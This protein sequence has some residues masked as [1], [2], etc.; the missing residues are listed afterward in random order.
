MRF[1][2]FV[3][4]LMIALDASADELPLPIADLQRT[5]PVDFAS[6]IA[7]ILKQ[8]CLACH[9]EKEAEGGLVLETIVSIR[10]GGDSGEGVV[11]RDVDSSLLMSRATGA[12]EPLM[13][14]EDNSVGARPLTPDE[15]G[16]LKLWIEQ[17]AVGTDGT[18]SPAIQWQPIPDS[19][20]SAYAMDVSPDGQLAAIGRANR[21]ALVD[22]ATQTELAFLED[23]SLEQPG[24]VDVDL[25]QSIRFSPDANRIAT[26][27]FRTVKIWKRTPLPIDAT[28]AP[29]QAASTWVA[30]AP[31]S[32]RYAWVNAI[33][34]IE[35][36][37]ASGEQRLHTLRGHLDRVSG[38][39][40]DRE[41]R[42]FSIDTSGHLIVWNASS[43]ERIA[44]HQLDASPVHLKVSP[45]SGNVATVDAQGRVHVMVLKDGS[46]QQRP[47]ESLAD[48]NDVTAVAI[49]D[50]P[51]PVLAIARTSHAVTLYS[52]GDAASQQTFEHGDT[53][54]AL[55]FTDDGQRLV[56]GGRNGES[57]VWNLAD[58]KLMATLQGERQTDLRVAQARRDA[59][60]QQASVERLGK[61][62][63]ELAKR[64]AAENEVLKKARE[65]HQKATDSLGEEQ[66]KRE[67]AL[68]AVSNS[69]AKITQST[70]T[71]SK[72]EATI[73][74]ATE[75]LAKAQTTTADASREL[76]KQQS[77]L[78]AAEEADHELALK[79]AALQKA[80]ADAEQRVVE[81]RQQIEERR[82]TVSAAKEDAS[83]S[84]AKIDAARQLSKQS[85]AAAE[86]AKKE[87]ETN[88]KKVS[89]LD[90]SVENQAS[91]V[92]KRLQALETAADAQARA[93]AEIP[94]HQQRIAAEKRRQVLLQHLAEQALASAD[95]AGNPV[96]ALAVDQDD[97][98]IA[99]AQADG[100]VRLFRSIDGQPLATFEMDERPAGISFVGQTLCGLRRQSPPLLW[101][102]RFQYRLERTIGSMNDPDVISDR[103]TAL[104]FRPDGLSIAIGSGAPSRSGEIKIV[105]VES[106]QV[107]RD[108]GEVHSDSVLGLAF[109]PDGRIL[110][111]SA[112]DK[113][114]RLLDVASGKTIRSLE[115]HTHH[116]LGIAWQDDGQTIA[117]AGADRE[118][119]IWDA[120]TG[121]QRRTISGF[122][123]EATAIAFVPG[124]Q[125]IVTTGADG[126]IR[127]S[128]V[129][130]GKTVR[131]FQ[132]DGDF[133]FTVSVTPD[134]KNLLAGGESGVV[135]AWSL[136]DG[137][138]QF[139]LDGE[140]SAD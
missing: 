123:K 85:M 121:Q 129:G 81:V 40:W 18:T 71:H 35:V 68:A 97:S 100:S 126:Q 108:F 4:S 39:G 29:L 58:G 83:E 23:T 130:S 132:A 62:S 63:E 6:E 11:P 112:A 12:E 1:P 67:E 2:L 48:E 38:L 75:L 74:A 14:P 96:V 102:S 64:L 84:Q 51:Q 22:L 116:V 44:E 127:L 9:H 15:L 128:D 21:V 94:S 53:V 65:E 110:A 36:W 70:E 135:R 89:E 16:L 82:A 122:A 20:R 26:G 139:Q 95:Q 8:N 90:K 79:I 69:E 59:E 3:L 28:L 31:D 124:S 46:L 73:A 47:I 19:I 33:G 77:E 134:G 60:R 34:D 99:V 115:G 80:K 117:S 42:I 66:K 78:V 131:S 30:S 49:T 5:D 55:L 88:R 137:K 93:E 10:A 25:V 136:S 61:K 114:I 104:D 24:V 119:K 107:L 86:Q 111:S 41:N 98:H 109:S 125:Q 106:G 91:E 87:L 54:S 76:A 17:G 52:L 45:S 7:P 92:A 27:G 32:A 101:S 57:K 138:Q 72:A 120:T 113:A 37:D 50:R 118:V 105:A 140:A 43:G 103:V 133:L 13:P 56:T